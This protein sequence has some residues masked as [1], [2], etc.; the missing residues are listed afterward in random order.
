MRFNL[1]NSLKISMTIIGTTIGAGFASGREIWE[2]FG[3]Y[4]EESSSGI[5]LAT[6]LLF[7]ASVVILQISWK[8]RTQHYSE[9]LV[10]VI[11][12]RL[13]RLF[14]YLVMASLVTSTL[15]MVAGS[16]ATFQEWNGSFTMGIW[17]MAAAVILILFFDLK[18]LMS[19]NAVLI[20]VMVTV[21]VVVCLQFLQGTGWMFVP[22]EGDLPTLPVWPSAITYTAF[23][24][25]SLLA[26]LS[27][28]GRQIQHPAEI[29]VSGGISC[30]CLG[31]LASLYNYSLL[32]VKSLISQYEIP[33]FALM[34]DY[35][36]LWVATISLILWLAIY[37]TAVSNVHGLSFRL[38]EYLSFPPWVIGGGVILLLVPVSRLGFSNLVTLLYPLYGVL[39]LLILTM[40]LLY[41]FTKEQ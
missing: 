41:P 25:L 34:R 9:V 7:A 8:E 23:N 11:G 32:R 29:W 21:L 38:S 2:F 14:D 17:V 37:T 6:L 30:L 16:G 1:W 33:L 24:I 36:D 20:P 40:I 4:G 19:M 39:N 12:V 13:A 5:V 27:T 26:V 22:E 3:S 18:G 28:M 35:S 10:H 15:V 31:L